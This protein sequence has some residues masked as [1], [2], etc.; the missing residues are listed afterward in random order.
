MALT[1]RALY[2]N[3]GRR[4]R[5]RE[6]IESRRLVTQAYIGWLAGWLDGNGQKLGVDWRHRRGWVREIAAAMERRLTSGRNMAAAMRG[7]ILQKREGAPMYKPRV[8]TLH[9]WRPAKHPKRRDP[10]R[11]AG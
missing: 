8:D 10:R 7:F 2:A 5:V 3:I 4:R 9:K 6:Q 11:A 1:I